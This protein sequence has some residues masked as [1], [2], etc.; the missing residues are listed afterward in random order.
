[1][2]FVKH[3][4]PQKIVSIVKTTGLDEETKEKLAEAKNKSVKEDGNKTELSKNDS[5]STKEIP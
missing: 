4:D 1:M 5:K 3:G 2:S